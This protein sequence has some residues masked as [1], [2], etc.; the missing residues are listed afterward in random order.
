MSPEIVCRIRADEITIS[1]LHTAA[2]TE[3]KQG[4]ALRFPR[5]MGYRTDKSATE[6]TTI[7]EI[8]HLYKDQFMR[9]KN[10]NILK[11]KRQLF[12]AASYF[13]RSSRARALS[14][15]ER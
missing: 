15:V 1:P 7:E 3:S 8:E 12:T 5:F 13:S 4:Y 14:R 2:R 11:K 10:K 9:N 6:A